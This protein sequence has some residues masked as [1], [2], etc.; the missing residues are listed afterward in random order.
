MNVALQVDDFMAL[1]KQSANLFPYGGS[2]YTPEQKIENSLRF[3]ALV[4]EQADPLELRKF[5][6]EKRRDL[7]QQIEANFGALMKHVFR[8]SV[9]ELKILQSIRFVEITKSF[10]KMARQFDPAVKI[11][12]VF[13]ASR[14]LWIVNTLQLLMGMEPSVSPSVFAYS[15]L[16]PYSDNYLDDPTVSKPDKIEF[17]KRF[18][19]KLDGTKGVVPANRLEKQIFEL[20]ELIESDWDREQFPKVYESLLAIHDA[21]TRS[22]LL[23]NSNAL[24]EKELLEICIEKGGT[25]VLAD[26]YLINGNLNKDQERFCFGFGAFLQFVDDIQ[27]VKEDSIAGVKTFFTHA[28]ENN[29]FEE[30]FNRSVSFTNKVL[31]GVSCFQFENEDGMKGIMSKSVQM[32][33]LEAI[34]L[35]SKTVGVEYALQIEEFSPLSFDYLRNRNQQMENKRMLMMNKIEKMLKDE[36]ETELLIA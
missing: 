18:R 31:S 19:Q 12:D 24:T 11:E 25:S 32:L 34:A 20:V 30:V 6:S 22:I 1:W 8:F 9:E 5:D 29:T 17:S 4:K 26:G 28:A 36:Q 14:N 33:M 7:M 23:V 10:F 16:Y 15:M 3:N 13:Q 27:D 2:A 21:Q 35:N